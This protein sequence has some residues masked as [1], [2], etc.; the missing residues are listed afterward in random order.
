MSCEDLKQAV[1]RAVSQAIA[2]DA[3]LDE[4]ERVLRDTLDR[5]EDIRV[6]RGET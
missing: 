5:I 6:Y 2:G 3:D 1:D 4:V